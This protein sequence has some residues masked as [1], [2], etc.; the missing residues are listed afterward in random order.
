MVKKMVAI[1]ALAMLSASPARASGSGNDRDVV[2]EWN[3]ILQNTLPATAG[4]QSPRYF[5][6]L[7]IA[8]F[9]AVN[10]LERG[11]VPYRTRVGAVR[12]LE[13][14]RSGTGGARRPGGAVSGQRGRVR[15]GA[16]GAAQDHSEGVCRGGREG[17]EEHRRVDSRLAP[18]R[19]LVG[20]AA[21]R[22]CC[23]R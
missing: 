14:G 5:A 22:T 10:S 23:R 18:E 9:D 20:G 4:L 16:G 8:M 13:R 19:R 15:F 17:R 7:H 2:I 1:A 12:R 21:G 11:Y 3:Q 6:M